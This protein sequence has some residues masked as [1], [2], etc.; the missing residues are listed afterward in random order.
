MYIRIYT[1]IH[2][3]VYIRVST[4]VYTHIY[5]RIHI[6]IYVHVCLYVYVHTGGLHLTHTYT[7]ASI[8]YL[9]I[10]LS[11]YTYTYASQEHRCQKHDFSFLSSDMAIRAFEHFVDSGGS[12]DSRLPGCYCHL[13]SFAVCCRSK[14]SVR[15]PHTP[16]A[17]NGPKQVI[18]IYLSAKYLLCIYLEP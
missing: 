5:T 13:Q 3:C 17:S 14:A 1:H 9:L 10:Q 7:C 11:T 4:Y 16:G 18:S 6:Y 8:T 12:F 2:I 15:W